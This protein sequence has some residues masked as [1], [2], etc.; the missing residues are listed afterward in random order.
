MGSGAA[1]AALTTVYPQAGGADIGW[2]LGYM[3]NLTGMIPARAPAQWR[4]LSH[5]VWAAGVAFTVLTLVAVL[6]AAAAQL[7]WR[8]DG[9]GSHGTGR[10]QP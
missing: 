8:Q 6:T 2:T 1:A 3:L 4:A 5:G 7:L 9:H 10:P